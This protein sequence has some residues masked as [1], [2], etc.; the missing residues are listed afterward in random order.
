MNKEENRSDIEQQ[1]DEIFHP[2]TPKKDFISD[3]QE[4]L[5]K[6]AEIVIENP[7]YF[8]IL[9]LIFSSLFIGVVLIWI[10]KII[11]G[12]SKRDE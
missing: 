1:L 9:L 12:F 7:N 4:S 8:V 6:K 5:K 2:V 11:F 10:L 3:L